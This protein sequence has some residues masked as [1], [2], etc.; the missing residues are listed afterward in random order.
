M[1]TGTSLPHQSWTIIETPSHE[2]DK[3]S[4]AAI[5]VNKRILPAKSFQALHYPSSDIA[6]MQVKTD[7]DSLPMLII[8]I[9]NTKGTTLINNFA[10]FLRS[11]LRHRRYDTIEMVGDFNLHHP[12]WNPPDYDAHDCE[13]EDLID[14]MATNGLNLILPVGT[15]TFPRSSTTLDLVWGNAQMEE[16]VLRCKVADNHDHGSDH[17]PIIMTLDL[18]LE[19]IE[20]IPMYN[21]EKTNWDLLKVKIIELLPRLS[22][23]TNDEPASPAT[24]DQLAEGITAALTKAIEC[25]TPRRR[26][27]PFSKRWWTDELTKARR[28]TNKARNK[29]KRSNSEVHQKAWKEKERKY[30]GMIKKFKRNTWRKFVK[31]ADEKT[32]WKLKKYM[33]STPI[34]SYI[35]TINETAASNDEKAEIFKSTFFPPPPPADLSDIE[36]AN[37]PEPVPSPPRITLSQV[38]TAIEK[39]AAKKAPGP[40]EIP[41]L[42]LKKCYNEIKEHV[43]L[44]A[45]ESLET[46]HFPTIFKESNTLILRKP[47]K[48]DYSKPNAYR[49][50]ALECTIGKVLESIIA[51]TISYLTETYELLP[52]NHFGGRPCR[53]TEDA[54]MLLV[55]NIYDAWGD[56]E[57][58]SAI[59]MDVA[60]AFNNV[61]HERLIHNLRKRRIPKRITRW[62]KSFLHGRSTR[63]S[64]NGTE[65]AS[66]P[67]PAGVPQGSP[68]SPIL[69]IFYN[70]DLDIPHSTNYLALGF[71]DDIAYGVRGQT[72][73]GNAAKLEVLLAKWRYGD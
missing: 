64:F 63:I 57:V 23:R 68:L 15:V 70:S 10:T 36:G 27:C 45:Q 58:L 1:R 42:V 14:L 60:G 37:Y 25:T 35:P 12:L 26:I 46:G 11:H 22:H 73:E 6:M 32:I 61:H 55:E 19:G 49:P 34:S 44:L 31:E 50:I 59:R 7:E 17:F 28:E 56:K 72:A 13:A 41:N 18:K 65:S 29:F 21:F 24:V 40:D 16:K 66:F 5:Y 30:R 54:M 71:I 3:N 43:L 8:N 9:Y 52:A 62:I 69:Y 53:S 38:E 20:E 2:P 48:P 47:K 33:D 39:L 51:E 67:T 4:R